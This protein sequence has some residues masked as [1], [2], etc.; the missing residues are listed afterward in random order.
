MVPQIDFLPASYHQQRQHEHKA[1]WRRMLLLFFL[2]I[3]VLGVVQQRWL[4]QKLESRRDELQVKAEG[5]RS[6]LPDQTQVNRRLKELETRTLLLTS[7]Q[8]RV[9]MTQTL[10]AITG[11]LPELV[12]LNDCQAEFGAIESTTSRPST[13]EPPAANKEKPSPFE[14]D[15]ASLQKANSRA[16]VLVTLSGVAPDDLAISK[17]L[18]TLRESE[19]FERITL[20]YSGPHTVREESWRSFQIRL[21]V[22][23]PLSWLDRKPDRRVARQRASDQSGRMAR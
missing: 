9:P 8:L 23:N 6:A 18:I 14:E 19:L 4:R 20:V 15:L 11:S 12:S 17:Y 21:Q 10:A 22:K 7:L 13:P 2:A 3:A 16:G 1:V 5:L